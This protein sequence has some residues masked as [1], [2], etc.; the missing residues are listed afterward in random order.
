METAVAN[1]HED[2]IPYMGQVKRIVR[3]R[4]GKVAVTELRRRFKNTDFV[5]AL[6]S[7]DW[8]ILIEEFSRKRSAGPGNLT[9]ALLARRTGLSNETVATYTRPGTQ[10]LTRSPIPQSLSLRS[11]LEEVLRHK[12][13]LSYTK[14]LMALGLNFFKTMPAYRKR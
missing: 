11:T 4:R 10:S 2:F 14:P 7:A 8:K 13:Q 1:T 12:W 3:S 9:I 6:D 5:K